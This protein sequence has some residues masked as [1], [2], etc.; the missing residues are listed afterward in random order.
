MQGLRGIARGRRI[1]GG[2]HV[3]ARREGREGLE[4]LSVRS[5]TPLTLAAS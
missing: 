5:I 4:F 1:G 3:S 2:Q